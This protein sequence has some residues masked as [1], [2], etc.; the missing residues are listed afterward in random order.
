M[1]DPRLPGNKVVTKRSRFVTRG[2]GKKSA[3]LT[4]AATSANGDIVMGNAN[5]EIRMF[6]SKIWEDKAKFVG[7]FFSFFFT[8]GGVFYLLICSFF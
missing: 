7:I 8:G 1:V 4:C 3:G 5:G 6:S 2:Q